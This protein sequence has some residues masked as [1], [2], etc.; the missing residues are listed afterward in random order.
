MYP[1]PQYS[2]G[3]P[4]TNAPV[5]QPQ[6]V[7]AYPPYQ[8]QYQQAQQ[9]GQ[10]PSFT[11]GQYTD[12]YG[13]PRMSPGKGSMTPAEARQ[14]ISPRPRNLPP[15]ISSDVQDGP[16][17]VDDPGWRDKCCG[18]VFIGQALIVIVM[19][20]FYISKG[21]QGSTQISRYGSFFAMGLVLSALITGLISVLYINLIKYLKGKV[22]VFSFLLQIGLFLLAG[23]IGIAY[24]EPTSAVI[25]FLM[26]GISALFLFCVRHRIPFTEAIIHNSILGVFEYWYARA[27]IALVV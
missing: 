13:A 11:L 1:A 18:I 25:G 21:E 8:G 7:Y 24:K 12:D 27:T 10:R 19:G 26:A 9:S 6:Y 23:I 22:V 14:S 4:P 17:G 16:P 3:I 2:Y 5:Y 15:N 20:S